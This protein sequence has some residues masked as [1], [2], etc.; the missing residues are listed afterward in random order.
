MQ[1]EVPQYIEEEARIAGPFNIR[2]FFILFGGILFCAVFFSMFKFGM[3]LFLS[4]IVLGATTALMLGKYN[5]RKL[6]EIILAAIKHVW[7]P[8]TYVWHKQQINT[9]DIFIEE[10]RRIMI[11]KP[12]QEQTSKIFS[13]EQLQEIAKGLDQKGNE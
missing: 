2:Q 4:V 5:G 13:S 10:Q 11:E 1:Y 6:S 8:K 9:Q 3:A 12:K 7:I